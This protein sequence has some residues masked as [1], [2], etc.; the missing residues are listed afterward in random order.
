MS[1][2]YVSAAQ[3]QQDAAVAQQIE[4]FFERPDVAVYKD[5]Y[6]AVEKGSKDW[7]NLTQGQIKKRYEV[8][9][10]ANRILLGA[11]KMDQDMPL[12]EAFERAHFLVTKDVQEVAIRKTIKAKAV[13]RAKSLT[14]APTDAVKVK[15]TGVKTQ[16]EIEANAAR[17]LQKLRS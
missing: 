4:T 2:R 17:T 8:A 1:P 3:T 13:K 6:G 7:D 12:D 5:T 16:A 9:E 15:P 14:L 11:Q 10:E